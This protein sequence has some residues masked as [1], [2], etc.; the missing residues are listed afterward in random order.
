MPIILLYFTGPHAG[1]AGCI[2]WSWQLLWLL[3]VHFRLISTHNNSP[4]SV[5]LHTLNSEPHLGYYFPA[6][7]ASFTFYPG[8]L[9]VGVS[10]GVHLISWEVIL[11]QQLSNQVKV[12]ECHGQL[13]WCP[14]VDYVCFQSPD[15]SLCRAGTL[16]VTLS[17]LSR[18]T[19]FLDVWYC[20]CSELSQSYHT[21]TM[22]S[23]NA[24][25]FVAYL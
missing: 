25:T 10:C 24:E 9:V 2:Y 19:L 23:R 20:C 14:L 12:G 1:N 7:Y 5:P 17:L 6:A 15:L 4:G 3:L 21:C 18:W 13:C 16:H 22:T 8:F 11:P